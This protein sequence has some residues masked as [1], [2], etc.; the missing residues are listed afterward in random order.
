MADTIRNE[1]GGGVGEK[2]FKSY[3]KKLRHYA[4]RTKN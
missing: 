3:I 4:V 1:N 2:T